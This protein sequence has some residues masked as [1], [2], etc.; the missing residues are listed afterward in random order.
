MDRNGEPETKT[1]NKVSGERL[2]P[3]YQEPCK[4]C[5]GF[6]T[7]SPNMESLIYYCGGNFKECKV[8]KRRIRFAGKGSKDRG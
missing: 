8:Y 3:F 1:L 6:D 4:D 7:T 2:C 5:L